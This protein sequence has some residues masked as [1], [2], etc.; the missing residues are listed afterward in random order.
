MHYFSKYVFFF[1]SHFRHI[2][3]ETEKKNSFLQYLNFSHC[4]R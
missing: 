4:E 1:D 3:H 2:F